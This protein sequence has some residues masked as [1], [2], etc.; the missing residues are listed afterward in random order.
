MEALWHLLE[1]ATIVVAGL[2]IRFLLLLA[3]IA[4]VLAIVLPFVYA[5]EGVRMLWSRVVPERVGGLRWRAHTYYT[6]GH[7]WL[8]ERAGRVRIGIDDLAA[9]LIGRANAITIPSVGTHVEPGDPLLTLGT[10]LTQ[11]TLTAPVEGVVKRVNPRIVNHPSAMSLDPYGRGWLVEIAP[12]D[13]RH[14]EFLY[15]DAARTWFAAEAAK[16]SGALEHATG[17]AAADGGELMMPS[18]MI[19]GEHQLHALA[20]RFLQG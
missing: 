6:P 19:I 5:G 2:T 12:S 10:G 9:H 3:G 15:G 20:Q 4:V 8:R 13:R 1:T 14:R 16:L 11:L 7:E 17:I 18:H